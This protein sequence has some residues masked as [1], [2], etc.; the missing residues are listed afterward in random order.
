MGKLIPDGWMS[1]EDAMAGIQT[2]RVCY[3]DTAE[4]LINFPTELADHNSL[5]I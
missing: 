1:F 5:A 4:H 2:R 3:K